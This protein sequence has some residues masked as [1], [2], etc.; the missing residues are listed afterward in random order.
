MNNYYNIKT[1][2]LISNDIIWFS[3]TLNLYHLHNFKV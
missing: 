3:F 1:N 2:N